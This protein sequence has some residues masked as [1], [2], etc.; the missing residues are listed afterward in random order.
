MALNRRTGYVMVGP[1][2]PHATAALISIHLGN[3]LIGT[4]QG[5]ALIEYALKEEAEKAIKGTNGTTFLE[6]TIAT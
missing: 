5:Y 6:K 4:F 1:K 2:S 3:Q